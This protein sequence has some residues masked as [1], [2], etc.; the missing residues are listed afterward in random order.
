MPIYT[1]YIL[2]KLSASRVYTLFIIGAAIL[3]MLLQV[4]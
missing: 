1:L 2:I 3:I 4:D